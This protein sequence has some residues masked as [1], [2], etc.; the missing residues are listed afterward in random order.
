MQGVVDV[1]NKLY[2]N[3]AMSAIRI[4]ITPKCDLP[5]YLFIFRNTDPFIMELNNV[6]CYRLGTILYLYVQKGEEEAKTYEL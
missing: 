1:C 4:C 2:S 5:H 3:I 6:Y